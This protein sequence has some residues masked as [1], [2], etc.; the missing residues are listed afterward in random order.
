MKKTYTKPEILFEDFTMSANIAAGC[1]EKND[2][3]LADACG[4]KWGKSTIFTES[5][6]GCKKKVVDG[7]PAYNGVCYHNPS[8]DYNLFN[9]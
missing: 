6:T 7:D 1:E 9:S 8:S 3:H 2:V 4:W 5:V